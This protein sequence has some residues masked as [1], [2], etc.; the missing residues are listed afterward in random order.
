MSS[1]EY[2][3]PEVNPVCLPPAALAEPAQPQAAEPPADAQS[4][5]A[6]KKWKVVGRSTMSPV[7]NTV[8]KE[9]F[10]DEY[11]VVVGFEV[12]SPT[13]FKDD[14]Q[15]LNTEAGGDYGHAFFYVVKNNVITKFL[16]FGPNGPGKVGWFD[17]GRANPR[18]NTG[19]VVKDGYKNERPGTPDY[20]IPEEVQLF[21]VNLSE[22]KGIALEKAT[23][24]MSDKISKGEQKY[25]VYVNDTCAET[26]R[27]VLSEAGVETPSAKGWVKHS[28]VVN[29]PLTYADNPYMW[30]KNFK[31][32]CFYTISGFIKGGYLS[33]I[34]GFEDKAFTSKP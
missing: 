31:N 24:A 14:T 1:D 9:V 10:V 8:R 5:P 7:A 15:E 34:A 2:K 18:Y 11:Y 21:R 27:Q 20:E 4:A 13:A 22:S 29:F 12:N 32:N 19:A 28:G 17:R 30:H 6:Q 3:K 25:T 26:A 33:K 16:S 23:Q